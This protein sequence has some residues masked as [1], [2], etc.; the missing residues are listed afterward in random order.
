MS[1]YVVRKVCVHKCSPFNI[2]LF[3]IVFVMLWRKVG[4]MDTANNRLMHGGHLIKHLMFL[5]KGR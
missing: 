3:Y 2:L 1:S 4:R 5:F